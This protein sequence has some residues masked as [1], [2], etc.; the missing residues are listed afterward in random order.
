MT[1]PQIK[2]MLRLRW[3]SLLFSIGFL[4]LMV[5]FSFGNQAL[6]WSLVGSNLIAGAC[7]TLALVGCAGFLI[8]NKKLADRGL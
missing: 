3:L 8:L 4:G 1:L 2:R 6:R 5:V 7:G